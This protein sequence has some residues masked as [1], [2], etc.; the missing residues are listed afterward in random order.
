MRQ[1]EH[2]QAFS[3]FVLFRKWSYQNGYGPETLLRR[4]DETLPYSRENCE[5]TVPGKV[6]NDHVAA[7]IAQ[8]DRMVDRVRIQYGM[9]PIMTS[10]P[11]TGCPKAGLCEARSL[12][13]K[14]RLRYWDKKMSQL[15]KAL[16]A[17]G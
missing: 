15:R 12:V 14:T 4:F 3:S 8:W 10:N 2:E 1:M 7:N 17:G 13:C 11:C 5:W 9:G 16:G 6:V